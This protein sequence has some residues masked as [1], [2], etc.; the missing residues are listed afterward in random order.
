MKLTKYLTVGLKALVGSIISGILMFGVLVLT[1]FIVGMGLPQLLE[2][3]PSLSLVM[4]LIMFVVNILV[5][6]FVYNKLWSWK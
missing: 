3:R 5:L 6:G 2:S 1:A 4:V